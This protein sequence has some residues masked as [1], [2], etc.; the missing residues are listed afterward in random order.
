ME[1]E[2][3]IR[4]LDNKQVETYLEITSY[5]GDSVARSNDLAKKI[6]KVVND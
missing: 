5:L 3:L 2:A 6:R 1:D 4:Y